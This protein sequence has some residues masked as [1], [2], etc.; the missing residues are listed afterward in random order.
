MGRSCLALVKVIGRRR[1]PFPPLKTNPFIFPSI[2]NPTLQPRDVAYPSTV[3]GRCRTFSPDRIVVAPTLRPVLRNVPV[4]GIEFLGTSLFLVGLERFAADRVVEETAFPDLRGVVD[5]APVEDHRL[6]HQALHQSEVGLAEL[7]PLRDHHHP[8]PPL[9]PPLGRLGILDPVAVFRLDVFHRLGVE[10]HDG[11]LRLQQLVHDVKNRRLTDVVGVRLER[12]PPDRHPQPLELPL[13][14]PLHLPVE[15]PALLL[16][17]LLNRLQNGERRPRVVSG[18]IACS[19][20]EPITTRSGRRKSSTAYPS[21]RNS[22]LETTSTSNFPS[23]CFRIAAST[24]SQ[25]PTGTVLL[26]TIT[27]YPTPGL[28]A[29]IFPISSATPKIY[30]RSAE[31]SSPGGVGRHRNTT[32]DRSTALSRFPENSIRS[33]FRFLRKM[34]SSPRSYIVI[35]P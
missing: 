34:S 32:G 28:R 6:P 18:P 30:R 26:S 5:V 19:L 24:F 4:L 33:F 2:N 17:D 25:V 20:R 29:R 15:A 14:V 31:P 16:V 10:H 9:P 12:Q 3:R 27:L 7:V 8:V 35:S 22:G 1:V 13:E 21:R 23:R 11:R